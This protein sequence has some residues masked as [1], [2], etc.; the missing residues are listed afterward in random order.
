MKSR[1]EKCMRVASSYSFYEYLDNPSSDTLLIAYGISSRVIL[2][3]KDKFSIFRPIRLFP[4]L[5]ELKSVASRY[6]R[7]VVVEMNAGQYASALRSF[8][9]RDVECVSVFGGEISLKE[10]EDGLARLS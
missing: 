10:V 8:L 5:E 4:V 6:K 7:I 3:L 9:C 1:K 2:P